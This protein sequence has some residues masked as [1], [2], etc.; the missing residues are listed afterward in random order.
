M[1]EIEGGR[2]SLTRARHE[3]AKLLETALSIGI[4]GAHERQ[5]E[6][7]CEVEPSLGSVSV[8]GHRMAQAVADLIRNGI[9]FTPDGGHVRAIAQRD[10]DELVIEVRDNGIGIPQDKQRD[11]FN[12]PFMLHD[13][14]NHHSSSTLEFNS[15][16]LGLGLPIARGIIEAHGGKLLV[17]SRPGEGSTFTIRLPLIDDE[18]LAAAA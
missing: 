12:R 7:A 18:G 6:I 15:A 9:R 14:L 3:V 2:P 10:Q 16:G 5:V 11:L 8:D 4:A 13:S 17:E 1:A